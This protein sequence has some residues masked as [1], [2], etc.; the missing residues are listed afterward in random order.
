MQRIFRKLSQ[1]KRG[2]SFDSSFSDVSLL[3]LASPPAAIY[4]IGNGSSLNTVQPGMLDGSFTIGT[5]RSWLWGTTDVLI[6]RDSRIT[7]ELE[8]FGVEK[9]KSL[10][11]AGSRAFDK[12]KVTISEA[13]K[14]AVDYVFTDDWKDS[15]LGRGIK[16]NGII[17][18]ALAVA[19]HIS[20]TAAIHLVGTDLTTAAD[21]HHFFNSYQ[22]FN[23]GFYKHHWEPD[24]FNYQKR[25]DMMLRNFE[26]L[27]KRGLNIINHSA[28]S[29]L[30]EIFGYTPLEN[31]GPRV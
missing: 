21:S 11:L 29:R 1:L 25:L 14:K 7:E 31:A 30:T 27:K 8:F 17:F 24:S 4:I 6:W 16:W 3:K 15:I 18:H 26:L 13:T 5:N 9:N 28:N 10:W 22:G 20:P 19:R 23:Q 2:P 12:G